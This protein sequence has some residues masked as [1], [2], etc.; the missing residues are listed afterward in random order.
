MRPERAGS[1]CE[2]AIAVLSTGAAGR[3]VR[4][5]RERPHDGTSADAVGEHASRP[6]AVASTACIAWMIAPAELHRWRSCR[7]CDA[8]QRQ[9]LLPSSRSPASARATAIAPARR[10]SMLASTAGAASRNAGSRVERSERH[11]S[12]ATA[13]SSAAL[14]ADAISGRRRVLHRRCY[15]DGYVARSTTMG[16]QVVA[17]GHYLRCSATIATNS[18]DSR[19]SPRAAAGTGASPA[20]CR[21][22]PCPASSSGRPRRDRCGEADASHLIPVDESTRRRFRRSCEMAH[23]RADVLRRPLRPAAHL[24]LLHDARGRDRAEG[25]RQAGEAGSISPPR[26]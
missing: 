15:D 26:R 25:D 11:A 19:L 10:S 5:V 8:G 1:A 4:A 24:L 13:A 12:R 17:P 6:M 18:A 16:E 21:A 22:R 2:P 3:A 7:S 9:S 14:L 20:R 23:S